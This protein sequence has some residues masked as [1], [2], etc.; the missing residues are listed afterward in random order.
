LDYPAGANDCQIKINYYQN[1]DEDKK[2]KNS[3]NLTRKSI[4]KNFSEISKMKIST[5]LK[6]QK[7]EEPLTTCLYLNG[8]IIRPFVK[9][10]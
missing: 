4:I 3:A 2:Q 8:K 6:E 9:F 5:L 7:I 1:I 10:E